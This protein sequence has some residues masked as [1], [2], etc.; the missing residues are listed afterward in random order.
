MDDRRE[1]LLWGALAL[2]FCGIVALAYTNAVWIAAHDA[3]IRDLDYRIHELEEAVGL[4]P[5][6]AVGHDPTV[7]P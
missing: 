6:M 4:P 2:L 7:M 1:S 5:N 3:E